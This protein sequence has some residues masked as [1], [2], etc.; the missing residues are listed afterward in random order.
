MTI[1]FI[2]FFTIEIARVF[3]IYWYG[4]RVF[5]FETFFA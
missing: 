1:F 5:S 2:T 3:Y 4:V